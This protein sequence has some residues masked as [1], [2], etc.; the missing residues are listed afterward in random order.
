MERPSI[1]V[2]VGSSMGRGGVLR[3]AVNRSYVQAL[4]GAGADIALLPSGSL[5]SEEMLRRFHGFVLPGGSDVHPH[6]YGEEPGPEL[7]GVDEELDELELALALWAAERGRPLL[8]LCRGHQVVNVALGGTLYQDILTD[9]VSRHQHYV[10]AELGRNHL[11]HWIDV[12]PDSRLRRV[13]GA[14]SLQ[15]NSFHHQAVKR[16]ASG[17]RVSATSRDD[18]I[19]E[20]LESADG[21]ILTVQCHPEELALKWSRALFRAFVDA[22]ASDSPIGNQ[23]APEGGSGAAAIRREPVAGE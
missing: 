12:D 17:L 6:H 1:G 16:V 19:V 9:G 21:R 23:P 22:A 3:F 5:L 14:T 15:V 13:V 11:D 10:P 7:G 8:G 4:R 20:G 18:G 2:T